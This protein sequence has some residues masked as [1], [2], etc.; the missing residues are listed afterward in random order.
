MQ[1]SKRHHYTP[2]YYL[3][4]FENEAGALWRL[5]KEKS[6]IVRGNNERF[7]FKNQWNTLRNPPPGYE[8]D[9]A[10]KRV[11]EIDGLASA[12]LNR[13][14]AGELPSDIGPVAY[15]I[16]FMVYNQPRLMRE[17]EE[18]HAE[19]VSKWSDDLRLIVKIKAALDCGGDY[20]PK[21]YAV[22]TID[23]KEPNLRFLTSSNPV[24]DFAD[25]PT[26][27]FP[28]S[29][30]QCLFMS[31]DPAHTHFERKI[32]ICARETVAGINR[33]T[34]ENAW[35]YIYSSTSFFLTSRRL[36]SA[37]PPRSAHAPA[38]ACR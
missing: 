3:K 34:I 11:S 22:Q 28:I 1:V 24:I 33:R 29:S 13:I 32:M 16:S 12:V 2:R 5:D 15:A 17:L 6:T 37:A 27:L 25:Q 35:Q 18:Q 14:L 9:W 4:R 8:P 26:M 20:V 36:K 31:W 30:R 23:P 10:E 21:Y 7:G 38:S 19:T